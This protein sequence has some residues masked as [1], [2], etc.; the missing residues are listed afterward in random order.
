MKGPEIVDFSRTFWK[1]KSTRNRGFFLKY[2]GILKVRKSWTLKTWKYEWTRSCGF[3]KNVS[4][5]LIFFWK[6]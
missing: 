6:D 4:K 5:E 1:D 3:F 2:F